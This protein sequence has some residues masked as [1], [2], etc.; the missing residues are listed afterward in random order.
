MSGAPS[1]LALLLLF[2]LLVMVVVFALIFLA[3]S[4]TRVA[5]SSPNR[6]H[7]P[8]ID[9]L[10]EWHLA[11]ALHHA[12]IMHQHRGVVIANLRNRFDQAHGQIKFAALPISRKILRA[13]LD[14]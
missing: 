9:I 4:E 1:I 10:H 6:E 11:Q 2:F 5:Q 3:V 12:V 13:L 7:A 8:M 14:R